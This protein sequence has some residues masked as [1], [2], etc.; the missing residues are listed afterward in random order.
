MN[1]VKVGPL[2]VEFKSIVDEA[3]SREYRIGDYMD[4]S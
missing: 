2:A 1:E 3:E 4:L